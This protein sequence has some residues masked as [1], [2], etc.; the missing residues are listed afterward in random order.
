MPWQRI[1]ESVQFVCEVAGLKMSVA[2]ERKKK[3]GSGTRRRRKDIVEEEKSEKAAQQGE[4]NIMTR[5]FRGPEETRQR[6]SAAIW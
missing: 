3:C 1:K 4:K 5:L 2:D 6:F